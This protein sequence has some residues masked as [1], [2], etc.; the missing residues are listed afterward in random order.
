VGLKGNQLF[1]GT[2][3]KR[4]T[5]MGARSSSMTYSHLC[6]LY[7]S[8]RRLQVARDQGKTGGDVRPNAQQITLKH[9]RIADTTEVCGILQ[10]HHLIASQHDDLDPWGDEQ[11][12]AAQALRSDKSYMKIM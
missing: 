3:P 12:R 7:D 4:S 2:H 10:P 5:Q 9:S 1:P 6:L 8:S 11:S